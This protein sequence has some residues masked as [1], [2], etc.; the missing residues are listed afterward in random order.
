MSFQQFPSLDSLA[1]FSKHATKKIMFAVSK[2]K[3]FVLQFKGQ[4][5]FHFLRIMF[6]NCPYSTK[7]GDLT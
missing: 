6:E 2:M 3:Y 4:I 7:E 1:R 5:D